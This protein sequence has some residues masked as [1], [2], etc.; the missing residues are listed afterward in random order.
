MNW[1]FQTTFWIS[2]DFWM[3]NIMCSKSVKTIFYFEL[4]IWWFHLVPFSSH[5]IV[6]NNYYLFI[7]PLPISLLFPYCPFFP[8]CRA[9]AALIIPHTETL[10]RFSCPFAFLCIVPCKKCLLRWKG[11]RRWPPHTTPVAQLGLLFC[12]LFPSYKLLPFYLLFWLLLCT[13]LTL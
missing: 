2:V 12:S 10:S 5:I 4:A 9:L 3:W 7:S 6:N 11:T 13:E 1:I 8:S